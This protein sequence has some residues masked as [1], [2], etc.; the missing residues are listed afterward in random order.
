[1]QKEWPTE[2]KDMYVAREIIAQYG[3]EQAMN[4]IFEMKIADCSL[5]E[6]MT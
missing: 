2:N 3:V 4:A 6:M 1:M 5:F